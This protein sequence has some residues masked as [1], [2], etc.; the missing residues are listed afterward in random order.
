[1]SRP[2]RADRIG[3]ADSQVTQPRFAVGSRVRVRVWHPAGHTRCPRYVR[4]QTGTVVRADGSFSVPDVEAH[5][6]AC[7]LEP[8]Y[9]VRFGAA[10]LWGDGQ[11]RAAVYVDLWESYLEEP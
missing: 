8:T 11:P 4:G 10:D 7:R 9:S 5:S 6:D 1:L 3:A 2:V